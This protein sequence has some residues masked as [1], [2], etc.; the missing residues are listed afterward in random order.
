[1]LLLTVT[2]VSTTCAIVIFRVKVSFITSFDVIILWLLVLL[3]IIVSVLTV[4]LFPTLRPTSTLALLRQRLYRTSEAP[5]KLSHVYYNLTIYVL[6]T[7]GDVNNHIAE[8]HLHTK[9]QIDW[10]SAICITYSTDYYQRLT[11]ES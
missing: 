8:H 3:V 9:H 5:L 2:D 11:L 7:S 1:M 10:E 6:H 4:T